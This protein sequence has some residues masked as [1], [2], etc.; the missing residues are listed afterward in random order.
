VFF[1]KKTDYYD[2]TEILPKVAINTITLPKA[3][4]K[5]HRLPGKAVQ[6]GPYL[7]NHSQK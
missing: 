1:N 6:W 5:H 2:I 7:F 3:V 4:L